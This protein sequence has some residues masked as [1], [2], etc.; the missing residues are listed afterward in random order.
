ME[1]LLPDQLKML[2]Q[3]VMEQQL[4][5]EAYQQEQERLLDTY[6]E[7]WTAALL[8]EGQTDLCTSI[9]TELGQ[10]AHCED[11]EEVKDRCLGAVAALKGEWQAKV[12]PDNRRSIERFYDE[13]QATMYELMWWHTLIDDTSPLA[14]VTALQF[15]QQQGCRTYLDFGSGVGSGGILFARHGCTVSLAD[16][17]STMLQFTQW[18]LT[19]RQLPATYIDLKVRS[20][21]RHTFDLVTAMDVFEHLVDPVET[22]ERLCEALA[23]GGF[24]FARLSGEENEDRPQH[25]VRDFEPTAARLRALGC[26]KVWEDEWL[27]GHQVFR[28]S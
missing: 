3:S 7:T 18:R 28:K 8:L 21:P 17:S 19:Q 16:I 1:K 26:V 23:P 25:I 13:T 27:W 6:R 10:Y 9:L 2:W 24:L 14:Y 20:L 15:A 4:T 12:D 22:A 5:T 11:L